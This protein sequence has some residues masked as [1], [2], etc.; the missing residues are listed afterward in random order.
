M[1]IG[2]VGQAPQVSWKQIAIQKQEN[3][4]TGAS[5]EPVRELVETATP[6]LYTMRD[7]KVSV[8]TLAPMTRLSLKV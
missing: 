3:L 8:E 5:G 2:A 1:E 4:R 6:I 7:G